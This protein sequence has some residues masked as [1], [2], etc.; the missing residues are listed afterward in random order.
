M[1]KKHK[2][3]IIVLIIVIALI[4]G[5]AYMLISNN[6]SN[7]KE[8]D[9]MKTFKFNGVFTMSVPKD[10]KFLKSWNKS[11]KNNLE[12]FSGYEYYDKKYELSVLTANS[13]I[14]NSKNTDYLLGGLN[15]TEN[16]TVEKEGNLT[17]LQ[18]DNYQNMPGKIKTKYRVF[19]NNGNNLVVV[20]GNDLD[21]LKSMAN[22]IKFC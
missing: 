10:S 12:L 7:N 5:I 14:M 20:A 6:T 1:E 13:P 8:Y 18:N 2:I 17:I 11:D 19:I 16:V 9:N 4:A 3:I 22:S 15:K 21:L